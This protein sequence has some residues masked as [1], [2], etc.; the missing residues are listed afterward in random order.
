MTD[1]ATFAPKSSMLPLSSHA[2]CQ[3]SMKSD[4]PAACPSIPSENGRR[5]VNPTQQSTR[6][7]SASVAPSSSSNS[8]LALMLSESYSEMETLQSELVSVRARAE[9]AE[10]RAAE[11]EEERARSLAKGKGRAIPDPDTRQ[12]QD[13]VQK[14]QQSLEQLTI[15][16][17]D[18]QK[19]C[20]EYEAQ[21]QS[22]LAVW[23]DID[24]LYNAHHDTMRGAN[25]IVSQHFHAVLNG[26]TR[27]ERMKAVS[28]TGS[29]WMGGLGSGQNNIHSSKPA[30]MGSI[31][32]QKA[33]PSSRSQSSMSEGL[34]T[35]SAVARSS[36]SASQPRVP[37][38][39]A[40]LDTLD[41]RPTISPEIMALLCAEGSAGMNIF[42]FKLLF[43]AALKSNSFVQ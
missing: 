31:L 5:S 36:S 40:S 2:T 20:K 35:R 22:V 26:S 18:S 9:A 17:D 23:S 11:L 39:S 34:M 29:E 1:I 27:Q 43:T 10:K 7:A 4:A 42:L 12:L 24:G 41:S 14:L 33:G 37:T 3:T 8:Q 28:L 21:H 16:Y 19:L 32:G 30:S 13:E 38:A 15:L 6:A 25:R